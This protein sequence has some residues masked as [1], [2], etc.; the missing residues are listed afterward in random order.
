MDIKLQ[1]KSDSPIFTAVKFKSLVF[2]SGGGGG[3]KFGLPNQIET[4]NL[5]NLKVTGMQN[6]EEIFEKLYVNESEDYLLAASETS[7]VLFE[8][9]LGKLV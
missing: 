9:R 7:L 3:Q 6:T 5:N 2:A 4:F 1:N 8:I